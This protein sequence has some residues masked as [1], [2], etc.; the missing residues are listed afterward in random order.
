MRVIIKK[1]NENAKLP[2]KAHESD[3]GY[4]VYAVSEKEIASNVWE[5]GLG[6]AYEIKRETKYKG[7]PISIDF[8]PRSSIYKTGM[9][10][11]NFVSNFIS[12]KHREVFEL[13]FLSCIYSYKIITG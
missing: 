6:F 11:S 7:K 12:R 1:L 8:R 9:V 2:E 13:L 4:D 5:Y 3:F 10:L